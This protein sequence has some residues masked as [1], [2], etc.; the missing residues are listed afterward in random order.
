MNHEQQTE[1]NTARE[2]EHRDTLAH[3]Q[4]TF[5]S[6]SG[7]A[8]LRHLH[9]TAGTRLSSFHPGGNGAG[10]DAIAAAKRDGGKTLVWF[11]E[12]ILDEARGQGDPAKPATT[13]GPKANRAHRAGRKSG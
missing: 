4:R 13:G 7:R 10:M 8:V 9:A 11:I 1:K 12:S 5:D 3:Y 2:Q 6:E